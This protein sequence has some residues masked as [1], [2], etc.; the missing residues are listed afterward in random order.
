MPSQADATDTNMTW[1]E[2]CSHF[3]SSGSVRYNASKD[4]TQTLYTFTPTTFRATQK[5][6]TQLTP[7]RLMTDKPSI[8]FAK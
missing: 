1:H 5:D 2:S 3:S 7:C 8:V 4:I 6:I